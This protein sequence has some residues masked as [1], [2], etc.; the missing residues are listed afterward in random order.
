M[1]SKN[2]DMAKFQES[3]VDGKISFLSRNNHELAT[4][5]TE[6]E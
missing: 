1:P 3:A 5:F 2:K 4:E 6:V